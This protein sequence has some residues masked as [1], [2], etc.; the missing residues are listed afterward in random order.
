MTA[1]ANGQLKKEIAKRQ[2]IEKQLKR[3]QAELHLLSA[4]LHSAREQESTRIAREIHD[5][6][7]A[8]LTCLRWDLVE[9]KGSVSEPIEL[10]HL[11]TLQQKITDLVL[12]TDKIIDTVRRIASELRPNVLDDLGLSEAIQWYAQQFQARTGIP[13]HCTCQLATAALSRKLSTA[14]FRILQ[15][16]LTNILRHA[17]ATRVE[18]ELQQTAG[19]VCLVIRD[20]GI[21]ITVE[22][23]AATVSLGLLGM[24]ERARLV[25]GTFQ[26]SGAQGLGTL[27]T[28]R[29]PLR[30]KAANT[31]FN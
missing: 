14:L 11:A 7:G 13:V 18:V 17:Q 30:G 16:A 25:G 31:A 6:L 8:L 20:N 23:Q 12:L 22:E 10:T 5:E 9:I 26:I 29:V 19:V 27:I 15:E 28:V 1:A 24:R 4:R 3:L 21:G 2:R